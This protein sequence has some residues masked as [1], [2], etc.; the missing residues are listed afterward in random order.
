MPLPWKVDSHH[1]DMKW[2]VCFS[3]KNPPP[4]DVAQVLTS[5]KL[6][7]LQAKAS[8]MMPIQKLCLISSSFQL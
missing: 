8:F 7:H 6:F 2:H 4:M 1:A 5:E 3:K